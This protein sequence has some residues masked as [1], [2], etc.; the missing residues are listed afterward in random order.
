MI[1][2]AILL[3]KNSPS[4]FFLKETF[5]A[6]LITTLGETRHRA[7]LIE[8]IFFKSQKIEFLSFML[9][10]FLK[11]LK[12]VIFFWLINISINFLPRKP[13]VPN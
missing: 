2:G 8:S 10:L 4:V 11:A 13:V 1:L 9:L 5:A 7:F 12:K 3:T 6:K